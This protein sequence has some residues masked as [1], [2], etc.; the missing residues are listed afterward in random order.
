MVERKE[1]PNKRVAVVLGVILGLLLAAG[2]VAYVYVRTKG[3]VSLAGRGDEEPEADSSGAA[4]HAPA[5]GWIVR[6]PIPWPEGVVVNNL[7]RNV[8]MPDPLPNE[9]GPYVAVAEGDPF[10]AKVEDVQNGADGIIAEDTL[11]SL[12]MRTIED[13]EGRLAER[14]ANWYGIRTYRDTRKDVRGP[15][16]CWRLEVFYYT[17][18][19]D[20]VP[21]VP[22]L[23]LNT[24]G[25]TIDKTDSV[26]LYVPEA[27]EPWNELRFQRVLYTARGPSGGELQGVAF[28]VL[29][30][31]DEPINRESA[32]DARYDVRKAMASRDAHNY[33]VKIQF[34]PLRLPTYGLMDD[35]Q[36]DPDEANQA[37]QEFVASF[38]PKILEQLPTKKTIEELEQAEKAGDD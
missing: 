27:R 32:T 11:K 28:H 6:K 26:V 18:L 38:M 16:S 14:T 17:G 35:Q 34:S 7:H 4:R 37:A 22:D 24:A 3:P 20:Q 31:N 29:G 25:A 2:A 23:C 10:Y 12:G 33:F 15:F 36:F 5:N 21:H 1:R 19:R 13:D 30:F 8:S 9:S